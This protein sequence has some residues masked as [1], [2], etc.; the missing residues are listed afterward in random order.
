MN[1]KNIPYIYLILLLFSLN[2]TF[3]Q[4]FTLKISSENKTDLLVLK[5]INYQNKHKDTLSLKSETQKISDYLKNIGYF[6]NT[7]DSVKKISKDYTIYFNLNNKTKNA[8]I[9]IK[10]AFKVYF[11][12]FKIENNTFSIPIE[13]LES[14][15]LRISKKLDEEGKSFSKIQLQNILI[16]EKNL[17]ADLNIN[18]SK[19]RIINKVIVKGYENFPKSYLKNYFNI[20]TNTIFNQKKIKEI[21]IASK[22]LQFVS[23]IKTPEVLFTKDSTLLYMYLK[24]QQNNSFDGI[25]SFASKENGDVLFNG[26]I[27]LELNN[28]LNT[29]EKFSLFWNSIGEEKQELKLSTEIPYI[30]NTKFSPEFSFSIYKQ[31]SIF[32]NSKFDSRIS[33]NINPKI[34][35]ALTYNSET[36][37]NLIENLINNIESYSNYFL[38]FQF[39]YNVPKND[40]F[41]NNKFYLDI[42]PSLGKRETDNE[43][44]N[45]FKIESTISYLW[46]LNLRNSISI[47]NK[48]GYLN[49]DSY[50][51]NELFRIGGANSIRG[52]N[53]QSLFTSNY[54]YFNI[55]YRYLTSE[56]SYLYTL[57]DL[58]QISLN[59]KNENLLGIGLGYLFNTNNSQINLNVSVGKANQQEIDFKSIKLIINWKNFF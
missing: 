12:N 36:S 48:T 37:E 44:I 54:T 15:L 24:K 47:K 53:E 5:K 38:G 55:E 39:K 2:T 32:L 52:F 40:F 29:G 34:K 41:F 10:P 25:V 51:D 17:F 6:T 31:D 56:K 3:T 13:K 45:Q 4:D 33:Y 26:N 7:I 50:I 9:K 22:S 57:T 28:I 30:F 59:S 43:S 49:S 8:I 16:K 18:Q 23:E 1:K 21:S 20:K 27:N 35:L 58:G 46:E 19:K 11:K 42:N 14:T